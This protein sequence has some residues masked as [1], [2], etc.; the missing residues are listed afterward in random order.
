MTSK[1]KKPMTVSEMA[2]MGGK[3]TAKKL[4]PKERSDSA[5][6]AAKARWATK[7]EGTRG[8]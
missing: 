8:R 4:T 2:R 6:K 7:K 1:K 5:R 3:A